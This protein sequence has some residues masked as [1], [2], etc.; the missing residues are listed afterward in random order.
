MDIYGLSEYKDRIVSESSNLG[1]STELN[2]NPP[3]DTELFFSS[4]F[5]QRLN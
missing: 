2:T 4:V 5:L 3:M 1:L